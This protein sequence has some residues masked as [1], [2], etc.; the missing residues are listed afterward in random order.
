MPAKFVHQPPTQ[1]RADRAQKEIMDRLRDIE[2]KSDRT[3]ERLERTAQRLERTE[4]KIDKVQS[5]LERFLSQLPIPVDSEL[6]HVPLHDGSDRLEKKVKVAHDGVLRHGSTVV[7]HKPYASAPTL[8]HSVSTGESSGRT[9]DDAVGIYHTTAAH[10]LLRWPSIKALLKRRP[11]NEDY[12]M[13][14]E[15]RKGLLRIYGKGQGRD[16]LDDNIVGPMRYPGASSQIASSSP[17]TSSPSGKSDDTGRSQTQL[18]PSLWGTGGFAPPNPP[19][20]KSPSEWDHPGGLN[21]DGTLKMDAQT[22]FS[23]YDSYIDNIH[24]MHP[25]LHKNRLRA[26]FDRLAYLKS[27]SSLS[28]KASPYAPQSSVSETFRETPS[29]F[30]PASKRKYSS[31]ISVGTPSEAGPAVYEPLERRT[32]TAIVLLAMALGK[33][34]Q[35]TD[36]LPGPLPDNPKEVAFSAPRS[37]S[38]L[39]TQ[40]S[41]PPGSIKQSPVSS[42]FSTHASTRSPMSEIRGNS[43]PR[44]LYEEQTQ[45]FTGRKYDRN[46][47]IIPGLAYFAYATDILGNQHGGMEL[48]HVQAN[49]LA[50]LY[51]GQ[52]ACA[53]ESWSWIRTACSV[54]HHIVRE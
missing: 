38:P 18:S 27:S 24:I 52:L 34:C 30:N 15:E 19:D 31:G 54:C 47:D 16:P 39:T 17:A 9:P 3:A 14:F 44:G 33:I 23:L 49:L 1:S 7:E 36:V 37:F 40:D 22:M 32:S 43:W 53:F 4:A 5:M 6:K 13:Q 8:Q 41:P 46:V 20:G 35:H 29:S 50:G 28:T 2:N 10:R 25:F 11:V 48:A 45:P 42:S 51:M 21:P 26:M 12:V